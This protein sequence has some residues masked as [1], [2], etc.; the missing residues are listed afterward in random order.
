MRRPKRRAGS[1]DASRAGAEE[2]V[3]AVL[4]YRPQLGCNVVELVYDARELATLFAHS[5]NV[6]PNL[7]SRCPPLPTVR[8]RDAAY[9]QRF[10]LHVPSAPEKCLD[11]RQH[12]EQMHVE[13]L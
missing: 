3:L 1:V 2:K 12:I 10:A 11:L 9:P 5:T 13:N 4:E 8:R 7:Y 6:L